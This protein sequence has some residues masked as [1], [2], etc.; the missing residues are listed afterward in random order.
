M[1]DGPHQWEKGGRSAQWRAGMLV[2]GLL[3]AGYGAALVYWPWLLGWTVA[4]VFGLG[5]LIC[6]VSALFARGRAR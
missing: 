5:G 6:V 4:G 2:G 1:P 3:L